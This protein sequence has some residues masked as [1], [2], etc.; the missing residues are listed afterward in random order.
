MNKVL[1]VVLASTALT[2]TVSAA[3]I[4]ATCGANPVVFATGNGGPVNVT[5]AS[6]NSLGLVGATLTSGTLTFVG[7]MTLDSLINPPV[8]DQATIT[9]TPNQGFAVGTVIVSNAAGSFTK[10]NNSPQTSVSTTIN[11]AAAV[12]TAVSSLGTGAGLTSANAI[13]NGSVSLSYTYTSTSPTP[14]PTTVSMLGL[15]LAALGFG[16]RKL[17]K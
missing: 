2:V 7:D 5:C 1:L 12:V 6:F 16:A 11:A 9:F 14:E 10:S 3:T 15:G 17:R 4:N 13:S 8:N